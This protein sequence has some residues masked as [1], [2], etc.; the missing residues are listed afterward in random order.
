[1]RTIAKKLVAALLA[2]IV[3]PIIA[4]LVGLGVSQEDAMIVVG[5]L[6]SILTILIMALLYFGSDELLSRV[7]KLF[8]GSW[9]EVVWRDQAADKVKP[10]QAETAARKIEAGQ[11]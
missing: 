4:G 5:N 1:M 6:E 9:A 10:L 8:P 3:G 7:K 2:L 11:V